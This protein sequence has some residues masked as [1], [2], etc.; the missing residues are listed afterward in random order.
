ML[1]L[2][3]VCCTLRAIR[4]KSF[5]SETG[6]MQVVEVNWADR[7]QVYQRLRELDITCGCEINQ[8]LQV[9]IASTTAAIQLWSVIRQ[10]TASRQELICTLEHC[11]RIR[12]QQF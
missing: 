6:I 2:L 4:L 1:C 10:F 9:E 7:W 11:W 5:S 3:Q 8:P 12:H